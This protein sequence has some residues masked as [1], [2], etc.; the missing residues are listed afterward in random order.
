MTKTRITLTILIVLLTASLFFVVQTSISQG[1]LSTAN[2]SSI[3]SVLLIGGLL[4]LHLRGWRYSSSVLVISLGLLIVFSASA[5]YLRDQVAVQALVPTVIGSML[6]SF[7]WTLPIFGA[8]M[9]GLALRVVIGGGPLTAEAF[10][11]TFSITN[12]VNLTVIA[13]GISL[14]GR[15]SY[16]SQRTAERNEQHTED[17]RRQ[18]EIQA[19]AL[20]REVAVAQAARSEAEAAQLALSEQLATIQVQREVIAEMS[21]PVLP[22][23]PTALLMPLIGSLDSARLQLVQENA[24]NNLEQRSA[25]YLLLDISGVPIVDTQVAGG[26]LRLVQAVGLLGAQVVLVG[27]RPEVAQSIVGLGIAFTNITTRGTLQDGISYVLAGKRLQ[28]A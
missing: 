21:V 3:V 4:I 9:L 25:H 20:E 8:V 24:L 23:T 5:T 15:L 17:A 13:I 7:R 27:I 14:A 10:G 1:G 6:L 12:L 19:K 2:A 16:E 11:P 28:V 22:I 18:L 26:L